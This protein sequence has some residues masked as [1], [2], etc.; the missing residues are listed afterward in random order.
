[1]ATQKR[2]LVCATSGAGA[3]GR[4]SPPSRSAY[5]DQRE[6]RLSGYLDFIRRYPNTPHAVVARKNNQ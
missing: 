6:N 4:R 2:I 1:M 5:M 3:I